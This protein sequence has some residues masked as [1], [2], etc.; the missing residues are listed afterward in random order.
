MFSHPYIVEALVILAIKVRH[1]ETSLLQEADYEAPDSKPPRK[2]IHVMI[3]RNSRGFLI[4]F[5]HS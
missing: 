3:H 2:R 1:S 5:M 4:R